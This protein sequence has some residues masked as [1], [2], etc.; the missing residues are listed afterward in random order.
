MRNQTPLAPSGPTSD[1]TV[2]LVLNDFS[3]RGAAPVAE[4]MKQRPMR[5][6]PLK[7]C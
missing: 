3:G 4:P 1:V 7:T 5:R 2:Y 6:L